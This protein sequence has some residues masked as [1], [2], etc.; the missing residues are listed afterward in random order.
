MSIEMHW[1]PE[2]PAQIEGIAVVTDVYAATSNI[3]YFLSQRAEQLLIVNNDIV[4]SAK[5]AFPNA[6]VTGESKTLPP[7]F[8]EV[9]NRPAEIHKRNFDGKEIIFMTYNGTRAI[10]TALDRGASSVLTVSFNNFFAVANYLKEKQGK[11][12][13]VASGESDYKDWHAMEDWMCI[14][15]L[16]DVLENKNVNVDEAMKKAMEFARTYYA[17][18]TNIEADFEFVFQ[19]DSHPSVPLCEKQEYIEVTN[20]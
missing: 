17:N 14:K 11:V 3:A 16:K 1:L 20:A 15:A 18:E 19:L 10:E 13:L 12:I 9:S 7:D 2:L 6:V 4:Q 8:F 5:E